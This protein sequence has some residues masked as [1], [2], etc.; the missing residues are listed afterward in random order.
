MFNSETGVT[1]GYQ[2]IE[3]KDEYQAML[4]LLKKSDIK[5]AIITADAAF[6]HQEILDAIKEKGA[7]FAITLKGNEPN[8]LRY[9]I[10][11]YRVY[12]IQH[13]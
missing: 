8:L 12:T 2:E 5:D 10:N 1:T 4:N 6:A 3:N 13:A 7:D 9:T 11:I